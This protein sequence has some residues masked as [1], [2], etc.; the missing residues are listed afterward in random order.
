LLLSSAAWGE[1]GILGSDE[2]LEMA[3][4][5]IVAGASYKINGMKLNLPTMWEY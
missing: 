3:D 4:V 2:D 5:N 1:I